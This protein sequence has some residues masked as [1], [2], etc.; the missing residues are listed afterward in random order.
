VASDNEHTERSIAERSS[1][2]KT[3]FR[4]AKADNLL[5][6]MA[7]GCRSKGQIGRTSRPPPVFAGLTDGRSMVQSEGPG[8]NPARSTGKVTAHRVFFW[9]FSLGPPAALLQDRCSR[10][11][12]A[13]TGTVVST[14]YTLVDGP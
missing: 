1:T 9:C 5:T 14:G 4:G 6:R 2:L 3:C 13:V 8:W 7:S 11:K 10:A 12:I